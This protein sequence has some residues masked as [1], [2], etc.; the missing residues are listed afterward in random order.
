MKKKSGQFT[1]DLIDELL[2]DISSEVESGNDN[3]QIAVN[4]E[5]STKYSSQESIHEGKTFSFTTF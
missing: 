5:E 4:G 3:I 1:D 2:D